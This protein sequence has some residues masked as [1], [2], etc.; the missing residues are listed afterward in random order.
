MPRNN[1]ANGKIDYSSVITFSDKESK[2]RFEDAVVEAVR[3]AH[4]DFEG[5]G[6]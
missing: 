4:P 1:Q 2:K 3:E 6:E 5:E